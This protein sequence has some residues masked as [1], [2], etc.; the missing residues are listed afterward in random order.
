MLTEADAQY[1][2]LEELQSGLA[3]ANHWLTQIEKTY[4]QMRRTSKQPNSGDVHGTMQSYQHSLSQLIGEQAQTGELYTARCKEAIQQLIEVT[5]RHNTTAL[6]MVARRELSQFQASLGKLQ[7]QIET[8]Q[9][10]VSCSSVH[11]AVTAEVFRYAKSFISIPL[12]VPTN[13]DSRKAIGPGCPIAH[14]F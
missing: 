4:W 5:Q 8:E 1:G 13:D 3:E 12:R 9:K 7:R 14:L 6:V 11:F 2:C 10:D